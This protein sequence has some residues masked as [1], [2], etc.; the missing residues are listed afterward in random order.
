MAS[1]I[2]HLLDPAAAAIR[3]VTIDQENTLESFYKLIGCRLVERLWMLDD[4]HVAYFDEEGLMKPT[5][6]L[7]TLKGHDNAPVAGRAIIVGDDGEGGDKAPTVTMKT[8]AEYFKIFRPV[9]V[10]ELVTLTPINPGELGGAVVH[11]TRLGSLR[12][13]LESPAITIGAAR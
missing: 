11:A 7:W 10:P 8:M 4:T 9:V 12:L 6:G 3:P 2:A 1:F 13:E 5:T